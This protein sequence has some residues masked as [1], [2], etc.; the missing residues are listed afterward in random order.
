MTLQHCSLA[1][2]LQLPTACLMPT[3]LVINVV[4]FTRAH[5]ASHAYLQAAGAWLPHALAGQGRSAG[6]GAALAA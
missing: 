6:R 5:S 3:H 1:A 4:G 2:D